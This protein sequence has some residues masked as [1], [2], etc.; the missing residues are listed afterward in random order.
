LRALSNWFSVAAAD[1]GASDDDPV[2]RAVHQP[3]FLLHAEGRP[4]LQEIAVGELIC[5]VA[6]LLD[7]G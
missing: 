3:S 6:L 4:R 7:F 2:E 5:K 1:N